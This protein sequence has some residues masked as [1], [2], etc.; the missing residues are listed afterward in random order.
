MG[1]IIYYIA[2][3]MLLILPFVFIAGLIKPRF[4]AKFLR[5][6][7]SR[8]SVSLRTIALFFIAVILLATFEPLSVKQARLEKQKDADIAAQLDLQAEEAARVEDAEQKK[9]ADVALATQ[10]KAADL[11]AQQ[12]KLASAKKAAEPVEV[13]SITDGDTIKVRIDGKID[14]VRLVGMNAPEK[15]ECYGSES[16]AALTGLLTG[17]RVRLD[18]DAQQGDRDKYQRLLRF[19]FLEDG[20][21]TGAKMLEGGYAYEALYSKLPH[22]HRNTYLIAQASAKN[23]K[24]GL[25]SPVT[26]NGKRVKPIAPTPLPVTPPPAAAVTPRPVAAP[27][28]VALPV[29][30]PQPTGGCDPNYTPCI[31]NVSY[32]LNCSDIR[33]RVTVIGV[34]HHN[35]DSGGIP[36]VGCESYN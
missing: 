13:V 3:A 6:K 20:S 34:D 11:D 28:P 31:P 8:L 21:N 22:I 18:R 33:V 32:D 15:S 23:S 24:L 36:N 4:F 5:G 16:T 29:P 14:I 35:L 30:A 25:W 7:G 19:V 12:A 26:C 1:T 10:R 27:N 9:E 2:G 17:K